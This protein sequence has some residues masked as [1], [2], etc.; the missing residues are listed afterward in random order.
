[1][2]MD[3]ELGSLIGY[4]KFVRKKI[5]EVCKNDGSYIEQKFRT[6]ITGILL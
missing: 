5:W 3:Y 1:M 4:K 2:S 6:V